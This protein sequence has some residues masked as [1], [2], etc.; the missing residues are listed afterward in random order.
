[1]KKELK[2][3]IEGMIEYRKHVL[4][5]LGELLSDESKKNL[6]RAIRILEKRRD[7]E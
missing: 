1:M 5:D 4:R 7:Y 6:K 2:I 3:A